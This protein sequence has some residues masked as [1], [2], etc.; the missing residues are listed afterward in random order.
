MDGEY[1]MLVQKRKFVTRTFKIAENGLF[2]GYK[3]FLF[4]QNELIK[5]E[6]IPE[7]RI[8]FSV[9]PKKSFI[10]AIIFTLISAMM[11]WDYL[12]ASSNT[13]KA[14]AL[15]TFI[16]YSP[17]SGFFWIMFWFKYNT[18]TSL[19]DHKTNIIFFE[20]VPS[21]EKVHH[22]IEEL[23]QAKENY[24]NQKY[25]NHIHHHNSDSSSISAEI[26]RLSQLKEQNIIS[27]EE[28]DEIKKELIQSKKKEERPIGFM[29]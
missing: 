10:A 9:F 4:K 12:F 21:P 19:S 17:I 24:I 13:D 16:F 14:E 5:F 15:D 3:R 18:Y 7:N 26:F 27:E 11:F 29:G 22:F 2:Y 8:S 6:D 20:N 1:T 23:Q 28:F 25:Y